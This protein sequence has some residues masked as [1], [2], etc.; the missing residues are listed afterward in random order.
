MKAE[1]R[2]NMF[3]ILFILIVMA[4]AVIYFTVPERPAF[5]ENQIEWWREFCE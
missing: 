2:E 3:F 1:D 4:M 5:F